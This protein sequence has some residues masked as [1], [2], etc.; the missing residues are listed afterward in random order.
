MRRDIGDLHPVAWRHRKMRETGCLGKYLSTFPVCPVLKL[1]LT[2]MG[3]RVLQVLWTSFLLTSPTP[4]HTIHDA[5]YDVGAER[6]NSMLAFLIPAHMTSID[7]LSHHYKCSSKPHS[8]AS[9]FSIVTNG[10]AS[11]AYTGFTPP[12]T[13][14]SSSD[15]HEPYHS[16]LLSSLCSLV[17]VFPG[18][19]QD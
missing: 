5:D 15:D 4:H 6:E 14:D 9:Q 7:L 2:I 19:P 13:P 3:P 12:S 8:K 1:S 16:S 17:V 18:L 11:S 10:R